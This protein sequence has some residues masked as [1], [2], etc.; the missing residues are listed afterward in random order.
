MSLKGYICCN[1]K[2]GETEMYCAE[3]GTELDDCDCIYECYKD[4]I[5][6]EGICQNCGKEVYGS[7]TSPDFEIEER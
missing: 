7:Y 4:Q 6:E 3:C 5:D 1:P 2:T